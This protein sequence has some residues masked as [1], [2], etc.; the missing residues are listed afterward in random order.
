MNEAEDQDSVNENIDEDMHS[1]GRDSDDTEGDVDDVATGRGDS[2]EDE[3]DDSLK[4]W[5]DL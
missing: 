3:G 5:A 2:D 1:P 4:E